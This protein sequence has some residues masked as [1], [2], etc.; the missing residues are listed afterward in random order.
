MKHLLVVESLNIPEI[1]ELDELSHLIHT[2]FFHPSKVMQRIMEE[3]H[4]PIVV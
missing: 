1:S 3:T 2:Y 4:D